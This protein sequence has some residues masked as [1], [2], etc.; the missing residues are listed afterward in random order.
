MAAILVWALL[1][2]STKWFEWRAVPSSENCTPGVAVELGIG[3][4]KN[5]TSHQEIREE[6]RTIDRLTGLANVSGNWEDSAHNSTLELARTNE[7][8][9]S[10]NFE[11]QVQPFRSLMFSF[12]PQTIILFFQEFHL[13]STDLRNDNNYII[14]FMNVCTIVHWIHNF[15][16]TIYWRFRWSTLL[17]TTTSLS[18]SS[19]AC[20]SSS[21]KST[22]SKRELWKFK[23]VISGLKKTRRRWGDQKAR[24]FADLKAWKGIL[25]GSGSRSAFCIQY[26]AKPPP[27]IFVLAS[28]CPDNFIHYNYGNMGNSTTGSNN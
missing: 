19:T 3:R 17:P 14:G 22:E 26:D 9:A 13:Q 15:L 2:N 20:T 16:I 21:S 10:G 24:A 27:P 23:L 4:L 12:L 1:L 18:S 25:V 11:F 5:L 6:Q 7:E 8:V 28:N